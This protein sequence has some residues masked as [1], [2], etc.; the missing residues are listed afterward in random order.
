LILILA[1]GAAAGAVFAL[2]PSLDLRIAA[3]FHDASGFFRYAPLDFAREASP[4]LVGALVALAG[5]SLLAPLALPRTKP[6]LRGRA[7]IFLLVT[8]ALGPGV[9]VNGVLKPHWPRPRPSEVIELGG[10]LAFVPWWD[11]RG[12]CDGNCSF[13]SGEGSSAAWLAAPAVLLPPPWRAAALA[14]AIAWVA[15][16]GIG[17]MAAGG[18]FASDIVFAAV[19]TWLIVWAVH[20]ALF[21]W[22]SGAS[23]EAIEKPL[24]RAGAALRRTLAAAWRRI[25]PAPR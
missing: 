25:R 24:A 16:I 19:F 8:F 12:A 23:D 1:I 10:T 9:L 17:R 2:A 11:P 22:R 5:A 15:I 3:L 13:V 14:G 21:R 6:L 18:H 4:Y 20:G 7:A